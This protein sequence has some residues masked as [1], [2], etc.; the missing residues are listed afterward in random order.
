MNLNNGKAKIERFGN[1]LSITIPSKKNWFVLIL[2]TVGLGGWVFGI[3]IA[4]L[5]LGDESGGEANVF[6]IVWLVVWTIGGLLIIGSLLWGYFGKEQIDITNSEIN[7]SKTV[8]GIGIKKRLAAKEVKNFRFNQVDE[9]M[10]GGGRWAVY[11]LG[12]G[13]IKFDYGFKTYSFGLAVD[14]AE[15]NYLIELLDKRLGN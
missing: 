12:P 13:K 4:S 9:S 7:F 2:A 1:S 5:M 3:G 6:I 15:A 11:G 14:E 10:F 8:F